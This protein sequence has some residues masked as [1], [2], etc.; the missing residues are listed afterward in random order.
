MCF[1]VSLMCWMYLW[2]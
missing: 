2:L 1:L